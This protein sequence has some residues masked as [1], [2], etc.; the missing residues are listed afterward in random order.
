MSKLS[1]VNAAKTHCPQGHPYDEV[2]TYRQRRGS[3]ACRIC[4]REASKRYEERR[5]ERRP[6]GVRRGRD[7]REF[8]VEAP[9]GCWLWT[10]ALN[11][12][13]YG[14]WPRWKDGGTRQAHRRV[15]EMLVGPIPEG[16]QIDHLCRVR[17]CVNP[18]HLEP[19]TH[20][21]NLRR[22]VGGGWGSAATHCPNGHEYAVVGRLDGRKRCPVCR[23]DARRRAKASRRARGLRP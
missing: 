7:W 17:N 4:M 8:Y 19:V 16:L 14:R 1:E 13:G 15:Y 3:R 9:S 18:D 12:R 5:R 23:R 20:A 22:A 10:G 11:D 21:E 2:N 6:P